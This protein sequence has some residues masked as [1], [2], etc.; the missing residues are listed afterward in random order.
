MRMDEIDTQEPTKKRNTACEVR[1]FAEDG[2]M[3]GSFKCDSQPKARAQIREE[4]NVG[5]YEIV[6]VLEEGISVQEV[7]CT[8]QP[9]PA[10]GE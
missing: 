10:E 3:T 7:T 6:R 4:K 5:R 8:L 1:F 2:T 9:L